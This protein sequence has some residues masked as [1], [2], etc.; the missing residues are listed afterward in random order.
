M[1]KKISILSGST[2]W[3]EYS[4]DI[5]AMTRVG[6]ETHI[7]E[8]PILYHRVLVFLSG[9]GS[10][11]YRLA[12][13]SKALRYIEG[14]RTSVPELNRIRRALHWLHDQELINVYWNGKDRDTVGVVISPL[15]EK[16]GFERATDD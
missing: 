14:A 8:K 2:C 13:I 16:W 5:D 9:T 6:K 10:G 1:T 11:M 4:Q 12:E 7:F 15:W 3:G